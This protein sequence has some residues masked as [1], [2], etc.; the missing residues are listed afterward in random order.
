[1]IEPCCY[2]AKPVYRQ[3]N[4]SRLGRVDDPS[5]DYYR[6]DLDDTPG[7]RESGNCC[8]SCYSRYRGSIYDFSLAELVEQG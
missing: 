7:F 4:G 1:M 6:V 3:I 2:C 8:V 5:G